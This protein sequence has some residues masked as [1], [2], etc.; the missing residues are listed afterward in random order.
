[1]DSTGFGFGDLTRGMELRQSVI[2][3]GLVGWMDDGMR[4]TSIYSGD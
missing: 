2:G 3:F 1:M 4:I